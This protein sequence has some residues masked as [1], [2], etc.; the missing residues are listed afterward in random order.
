[1]DLNRQVAEKVMGWE[2]STQKGE[3]GSYWI[4]NSLVTFAKDW[5]PLKNL[6]QCFEVVEKM[7]ENS[8]HFRF[9]AP[10]FG[11]EDYCWAEFDGGSYCR[12][13]QAYKATPQEAI[14]KAALEAVKESALAVTWWDLNNV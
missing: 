8:F 6:N 7:V 3:E 4:G 2:V 10:M 13:G 12:G 14:L 9:E 5:N 1:M 11:E